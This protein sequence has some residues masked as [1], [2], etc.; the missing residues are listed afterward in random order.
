MRMP[1]GPPSLPGLPFALPP[2]HLESRMALEAAALRRS[3]VW[4]SGGGLD[5]AGQPVLLIPG[6]LAGDGSLATMTQWLRA[7]GY[8]TKRAGIRANVACSERACLRIEERLEALAE[9][10]GTRVTVIGQSRGGVLAKALAARR[11]ELVRGI[12]TLGS[13][14]R[15]QLAVHPLVLL[16]VGVL[17]TLGTGRVPGL[18]SLDCLRGGCCGPFRDSLAGPFPDSVGYVALY[19]RSD[20][21]VD[22]RSCLDPD[23]ELVEVSASHCGMSL[24]AQAYRAVAAALGSFAAVA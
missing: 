14:V 1:L 12:V 2:L 15:D 21:V 13:P 22:W 6:F 18:F 19:S 3:S 23:A 9:S 20:G 11:P 8:R 7:G 10:S 16:Q 24:N 4:R 17:A 5:G